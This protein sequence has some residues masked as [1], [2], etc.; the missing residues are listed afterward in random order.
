MNINN[1]IG[2]IIREKSINRYNVLVEYKSLLIKYPFMKMDFMD[3]VDLS[4]LGS[5]TFPLNELSDAELILLD[6]ILCD[7]YDEIKMHISVRK[8]ISILSDLTYREIK[9]RK[10]WKLN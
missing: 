6:N 8:Y 10:L 1:L 3:G 5:F 2:C 9:Q 7:V 4:N